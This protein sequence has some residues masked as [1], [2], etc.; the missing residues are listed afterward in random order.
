MRGPFEIELKTNLD[1]KKT[2][3][4]DIVINGQKASVAIG[5]AADRNTGKA[6]HTVEMNTSLPSGEAF[7][8][9]RLDDDVWDEAAVLKMLEESKLPGGE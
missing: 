2:E 3:T 4:R 6:V 1:I 9:L 7:L 8:L 5:E